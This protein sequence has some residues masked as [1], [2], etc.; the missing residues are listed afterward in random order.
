MAV[1]NNESFVPPS[2]PL[3]GGVIVTFDV[4]GE[5]FK[6]WITNPDTIQQSWDLLTGKSK[7]N[8]PIGKILTGSGKGNHNAP[9]TWHLDPQNIKL[10]E[11]TIELCD[12]IPSH[13]EANRDEFINTVQQ[14]CPW[15]AKIVDVKDFR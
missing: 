7:A 8:I 9:Y 10:A 3:Q 1:A 15:S 13:V 2:S 5:E 12:A 11:Q 6:V 4:V 14:Y